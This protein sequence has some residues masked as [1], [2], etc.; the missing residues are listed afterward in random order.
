V[1]QQANVVEPA[2]SLI[3]GGVIGAL[4]GIGLVVVLVLH[5]VRASGK[6]KTI[7]EAFVLELDDG[8]T[9]SIYYDYH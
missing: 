7:D 8:D 2:I 6:R 1:A 9:D 5:L 4:I 3:I